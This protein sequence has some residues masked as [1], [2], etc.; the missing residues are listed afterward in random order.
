MWALMGIHFGNSDVWVAAISDVQA[1]L[2]YVFDSFLMRQL[3]REYS[4]QR[5]AMVEIQSR[6][7]SHHRMI[8]SVKKK[9]G[10]EGICRVAK[11]CRNE[12]LEPLDHGLRTQGLFARCIIVFAKT[13]G[14]I[15][16]AGLYWV[17]ILIWLGFGPR[18][19]CL[20]GGNSTSTTRHRR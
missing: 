12:P 4:E 6:C 11:K 2:C 8:T 19:N 1:I 15:I 14:H 10:A 9:L 13:F 18:C 3:L 7:N 5:E 17:C 20:T 16:S